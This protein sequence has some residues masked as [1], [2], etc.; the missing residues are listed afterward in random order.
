MNENQPPQI[1]TLYTSYDRSLQKI[2]G[3]EAFD[4]VLDLVNSD[5]L[6]GANNS[7]MVS[8]PT[9]T[10][11]SGTSSGMTNFTSGG[12]ESGK[13]AYADQTAG[14]FLG[15][16]TDGVAKF[17]IGNSTNYISW[18]GTNLVVIGGASVSSLN[19]PDTTTANSF[20][21]DSSGNSWWGT[22]VATGYATAP[23]SILNTGVAKFT[24]VTITGGTIASATLSG[25]IGQTNIDVADQSWTQTSAFS[26]ASSTQVNWG[27]GTFTTAGGTAYS[28][29]SGN[30]G[31]MAA[32]TYIYLDT[33]VSTTAYQHTT[34]AATAVGAGKV[35]IAVAQ[36]NTSEAIFQ[37]FSG[38]GGL[39]VDGSNIVTASITTNEIA[40]STIVANNIAASTITAAKMNVSQLSAIAADLGS[41]T[42]GSI[43]INSGVASISA[44][45]AAVFKSIQVG[46]STVQYT[47][48]DSGI[49]SYGD[50]SDGTATCD[51]ATAVAGM[52]RVGSV[53]TLTRDVYFN[54]LTINNT[55]TVKLS[56]YRLFCSVLLTDNGTIHN[57]GNNGGAGGDGTGP[58]GGNVPPGGGG[59]TAGTAVPGGYLSAGQA[60]GAG[61]SG[62]NGGAVSGS[63]PAVAGTAGV[64]GVA[65]TNS[66]GTN[67]VGGVAGGSGGPAVGAGGAFATATASNVKLIANWH[68]ATLLDIAS[69]GSTVK[70]TPSAG[71]GG[72]GG[73]SGGTVVGSHAS[74]GGGGGGGG[75]G[76]SAGGIVAIYAKNLIVGAT[77][78]ISSNGGNG[79]TGGN[80]GAGDSAFA[81][82]TEN[83]GGGG[84]GGSGGNGGIIVLV[85]NTYTN[86]GSVVVTAGSA[87]TG[88]TGGAQSGG[89]SNGTNGSNGNAGSAGSIYL[90]NLSL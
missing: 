78:V 71:N 90:F 12:I 20:H 13:Q 1:D 79:G 39:N 3:E 44:A 83:G 60:G 58:N 28:I 4:N 22:N 73:G 74:T 27:A 76:G 75:G 30:T 18:D 23:A 9:D 48:N 51:G 14:F 72:S 19:I 89:G 53:Y 10:I 86:S 57:N 41:I 47:L 15:I 64:D 54:T 56:S 55:V 21:V 70:F 38:S 17:N 5:G 43:N 46:G 33:S 25:L 40:A 49:F 62:G 84:G 37:V 24:N 36:N 61:G 31:A 67:S 34:T 59:G 66:L 77:G 45:G 29:G 65:V 69:S 81:G 26:V 42:A 16:D 52:S 87:G 63:H 82:E 11:G 85:Y 8:V 80:G 50:G 6:G 35:L 88:G 32:K 2:T 7:T 68:L